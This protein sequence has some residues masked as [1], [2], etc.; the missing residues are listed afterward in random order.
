MDSIKPFDLPLSQVAQPQDYAHNKDLTL[1]SQLIDPNHILK[2]KDRLGVYL[3]NSDSALSNQ[4]IIDKDTIKVHNFNAGGITIA[5]GDELFIVDDIEQ[6]TELHHNLDLLNQSHSIVIVPP[7]I[8]DVTIKEYAQ[9]QRVTIFAPCHEKAPLIK[10]FHSQNVRL[11]S[12]IDPA[13][14]DNLNTYKS[15]ADFLDDKDIVQGIIDC[16]IG[17]LSKIK[18]GSL[19]DAVEQKPSKFPIDSFPP[20]IKNAII[21]LAQHTQSTIEIA[22]MSI[23]GALFAIAQRLVSCR[24]THNTIAISTYLLTQ[25]ESSTGKTG[26]LKLSYYAIEKFIIKAE[27]EYRIGLEEWNKQLEKIKDSNEKL[28][29][30]SDNPKPMHPDFI[31]ED[32]TIE[33]LMHKF[34]GKGYQDL[35]WQSDDAGIVLG[36]HSF[37]SDRLANVLSVLT[38]IYSKQIATRTRLNN[39]DDEKK[40][41]CN[42][43]I[44]LMGQGA[45]LEP[46]LS[47]PLYT[48]Q[49]FL[50]R[51]LF[52]KSP[53]NRG[54]RIWNSIERLEESPYQDKRLLDF[55][56][57]C[58]QLLDPLPTLYPR[59]N[60][61]AKDHRFIIE[62]DSIAVLKYH[63]DYQQKCELEQQNGKL[64]QFDKEIAGR[65]AEN[66]CKLATLFAFCELRTSTTVQDYEQAIAIVDY[67]MAE[68]LRYFQEIQA[69][70]KNEAELMVDWLVKYCKDN[71]TQEIGLRSFMQKLTPKKLRLKDV[72]WNNLNFL[73]ETNH[74][75]I[76]ETNKKININPQIL[77]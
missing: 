51:F 20:I 48:A 56:Q 60:D 44:D 14:N 49:G 2:D 45:V 73:A 8:Y 76:D 71:Q 30:L 19:R 68:R 53:D 52:V 40:R 11:I 36:G 47:D 32:A 42:L 65:L 27:Q 61:P 64:Y 18:L 58:D 35:V 57:L 13:F 38:G 26:C 43:T 10:A 54:H 22:T 5:Q 28:A 9:K 15:F 46:I 16:R 59:N 1:L 33:A 21:A 67:C 12:L 29:F 6:A 55:W 7:P 3:Y 66:A 4:I 17:D 25:A 75:F 37:K 23:L 31:S 63:I 39:D 24:F 41:W 69:T 34:V 50:A 62:Y 77:T 74:I 70:Q 72:F